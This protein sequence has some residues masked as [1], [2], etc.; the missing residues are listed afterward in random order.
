[1]ATLPL[2]RCLIIG[3]G[4]RLVA[5]DGIIADETRLADFPAAGARRDGALRVVSRAWE[6]GRRLLR[7]SL[8]HCPPS[9]RPSIRYRSAAVA[10]AAAAADSSPLARR[11]V[12]IHSLLLLRLTSTTHADAAA[13]AAAA[14]AD[15]VLCKR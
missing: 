8:R 13:A 6:E 9:V 2:F 3:R 14:A 4:R 12:D 11:V 15:V 5:G 1:M 7:P 10:A